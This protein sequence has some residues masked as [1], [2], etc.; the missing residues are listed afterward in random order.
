MLPLPLFLHVYTAAAAAIIPH[1]A[2][3]VSPGALA[4]LDA[5]DQLCLINA[6]GILGGDWLAAG[7][8]IRF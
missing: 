4:L 1:R 5:E 6:A 7:C 3:S 8:G 2:V